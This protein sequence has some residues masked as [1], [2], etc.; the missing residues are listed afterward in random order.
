MA[1][2]GLGRGL[3]ALLQTYD[4]QTDF[5]EKE[6]VKE[7]KI[8][9][10]DPNVNQPR[11]RFDEQKIMELAQSIKQHGVVQPI[12][13]KPHNGRYIIVVG[14]RR[15]RAARLA[16]LTHIPAIVR[17]VDKRELV[18]I[19]LI[20]NLQREDLNPIEEAQGIRQLIEEY[21]LTQEQVAERIGW[22]RSAV[23]N[24]LRLL[25]LSEEIKSYLEDGR[26]SAGHA[27]ALLAVEDEEARLMLAKKIV[28]DGLSVREVEKVVRDIKNGIDGTKKGD[29]KQVMKKPGYLLELEAALEERFGTKVQITPGKKKGIIQMEY[30]SDSDL[31]RIINKLMS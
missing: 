25:S 3:D 2:R 15:W 30:Y 6:T 18:E 14:E 21:G 28:E 13:V 20:E 27:R 16:G 4:E 26:L 17:D 29:K 10:I 23:A 31:E 8:T 12:I 7:I 11:K 1:K 19:A 9:D 22:S 24:A 5:S